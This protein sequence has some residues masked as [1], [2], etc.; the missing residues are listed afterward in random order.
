MQEEL[1]RFSDLA[2]TTRVVVLLLAC[3]PIAF[4]IYAGTRSDEEARRN[5]GLG[6]L[7]VLPIFECTIAGFTL[8]RMRRPDFWLH[9]IWLGG[10]ASVIVAGLGVAGSI[11]LGAK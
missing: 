9:A 6:A 1:R 10:V 11:A 2:P 5:L 8:W 3:A 4:L 7:L